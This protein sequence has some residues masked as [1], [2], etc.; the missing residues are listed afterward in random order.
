MNNMIVNI[1]VLFLSA[2]LAGIIM[3]Y[4]PNKK[5]HDIKN[6]LVFG[7]AY[8]FSITVIHILPETYSTGVLDP[9]KIGMYVLAGFFV[10]K[11]L[12]YITIGVE[13]GHVHTHSHQHKH[14]NTTAILLLLALSMHALL[15][16]AL[17]SHPSSIHAQHDSLTVL[18]GI[19]LHK[20]PA[21]IALVSTLQCY[22][23][24]K[25]YILT[26]LFLFAIASPLGLVISDL[27]L[28]NGHF[29]KEIITIL[30]SIVS[31]NFLYISTT[32]FFEANPEHKFDLK[33]IIITILGVLTAVLFEAF[34]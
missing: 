33:K 31:G 7:G 14:Q 26:Y 17:L 27:S 5:N 30:F 16:G 21:A 10:Q 28:Q 18:L 6:F 4:L 3:V 1:G 22:F 34:I 11:L 32:I 25:K 2:F 19:A 20:I 9:K 29:S 15:E 13:H 8:L 24:Q 12:E 23:K